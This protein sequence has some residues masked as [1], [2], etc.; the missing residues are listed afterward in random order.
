MGEAQ[1][2]KVKLEKSSALCIFC[3]GTTLAT[4]EEHCPPRALFYEKRW[5]EGYAFPACEKCNGGTSDEDL[6]I[7][8]L[9][10]LNPQPKNH[11][12][13]KKGEG[14]MRAVNRQFP[15][16]L[17]QMFEKSVIDSRRTARRLGLSPKH[18]QTY[19][20]MGIVNVPVAM[21]QCVSIFAAK[22][23]KAVYYKQTGAIFPNDGGIMFQWF[24]NAQRL[25][26]GRIV[27]LDALAG[28]TAMST[29]KQRGGKDL[30][31]QFDYLYSVDDAGDL[32]VL[33][34]VFSEVFG[35]VTIFSQ[36]PSR[37]ET[38][39]DS[40]KKKLDTTDSPFEFLSTNRNVLK[41]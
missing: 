8:F 31:E 34:A 32:H 15:G 22:L 12:I 5:P 1:R 14:L 25:E 13:T 7:A 10:Q 27:L 39:E 21:R 20:E 38:I 4:T 33:Q 19:Q 11:E 18:G 2:R 28:I 37:L 30:K 41:E 3:G 9:A 40:V 23:T 6:M 16:L 24:T 17:M 35:F 26:H 29:P 36:T